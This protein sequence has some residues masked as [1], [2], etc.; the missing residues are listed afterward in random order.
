MVYEVGE[1]KPTQVISKGIVQPTAMAVD[2]SNNLYV[3]N[4]CGYPDCASGMVSVY[5]AGADSPYLTLSNVGVPDAVV[6]DSAG[7]V[8]VGSGNNI[9][10]FAAGKSTPKVTI[11]VPSHCHLSALALDSAGNLYALLQA[12]KIYSHGAVLVFMAGETTAAYTVT[13]DIDDPK[14]SFAIAQ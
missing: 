2:S 1:K 6:V 3:A 10:E 12:C 8:Y 4:S 11:P 14:N 7:T 5:K 13:K 9:T